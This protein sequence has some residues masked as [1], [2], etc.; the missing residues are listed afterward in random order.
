MSA[1][2]RIATADALLEAGAL[3]PLDLHLARTVA[4]LGGDENDLVL[5]GA[6]VASRW[7][8]R[9]HVC[10][11]LPEVV[12]GDV[13]DA[14][15][16]VIESLAWPP[17][18]RWLDALRA[19]P[20]IGSPDEARPLV[21][22]G[23]RRL[24]LRRYWEYQQRL[25]SMI[26]HR[27]AVSDAGLDEELLR[28]GLARLFPDAG[29]AGAREPGWVDWQR[30]AA[31]QA[32]RRRLCVIS[33]GPG[34][35]KTYTV[36]R[37][38]AL[39]AEQALAR[40]Q[41][42][43]RVALLAPTGKAAAR[44]RGTIASFFDPVDG[45]RDLD[46][47]PGV[48]EAIPRDASTIHR[49]LRP[50][51]GS[52]IRFRHDASN[53]LAADVVIVDEASMVD[54]SLMTRLL[55]AIPAGAK[56]ILLGD[57]DQ[58]A[59]VEAGAILGDI[60]N[61]DAGL[62]PSTD[63][64]RDIA[65]VTGQSLPPGS[66][67]K[68]TGIWDCIVQLEHSYRYGDA[69]DIAALARAIRRGDAASAIGLLESGEHA[70][71]A[72]VEQDGGAFVRVAVEG[73]RACLEADDPRTA[74]AAYEGFRV[75]CPLRRGPQ[76]LET[77][78][79]VIEQALRRAGLLGGRGRWYRGRPV[80]VTRNDYQLQ[81]FNGD[82]GLVLPS[83]EH[84][85]GLRAFFLSSTGHEAGAPLPSVAPSRLPAHETAFAMSVHKSQGSEFDEVVVLL[86]GRA[87]PLL[88][89]ELLYTA[90]SRARKKVTVFGS[91]EIVAR[92]VEARIDRASGL[93][94]EIWRW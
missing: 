87:S 74:L 80:L 28:D 78:N 58:L 75:L 38:L 21:L 86:P 59:S 9:G 13:A 84:D 37:I 60:C 51:R 77:V 11:D 50:V 53:P 20:V 7:T 73:Y 23:G 52:S 2:A 32:L 42:A 16:S 25:A 19:S 12:R 61:A 17:L 3:S 71:I 81:L 66:R 76:G 34:T 54:L 94:E 22:D 43:P 39:L 92:A 83:P 15:G 62:G 67:P 48:R 49:C 6:A 31:L 10:V 36:A 79:P 69:T 24:Y 93:R 45:A 29:M 85:G 8:G 64:V 14:D 82:A 46:L 26:R 4:R 35:G 56:L 18:E 63:T 41:A 1:R 72:L 5:L 40:G 57:R 89:R 65:R 47:G 27:A 70:S 55:D 88:T 33:G 91:R 90:V 30:V 44:L 68:T